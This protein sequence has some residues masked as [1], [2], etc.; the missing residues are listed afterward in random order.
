VADRLQRLSDATHAGLLASGS[1]VLRGDSLVFQTQVS[2]VQTG[3][4][5]LTLDAMAGS[6]T[7]PI[8]AVDALGDRLL[9][10][11]NLRR[12]IRIL[13]QGFRA[14][15]YAAYREFA[16][17]YER[18]AE[19]GDNIGSRPFFERAI[20]LDSTYTQ[21][22]QLLVRQY[23]NAD[24][25][26]RAD[27]LMRRIDRLPGGLTATER[28]QRDYAQAE[29]DGNVPGLLRAAEQLV[30]RDSS[31]LALFLTGEAATFLLKP[32]LAVPALESAGATYGLIGGQAAI[33]LKNTLAEA[34][35]Q[36]GMHDRELKTLV[37]TQR[38]FAATVPQ[39]RG[40]RLRAYAGLRDGTTA[41]AVADS[42]L[43]DASDSTGDAATRVLRGAEEFRA[44]GDQA[45]AA[46][47]LAMAR[48]WYARIPARTPTPARRVSEG[49]A[50]L[51]SGIGDSAAVRFAAVARD[52]SRID[53]AGYL[54]LANVVRGDRAQARAIADSLGAMR[55]P[56][57][58]GVHTFWRGAIMG[59]LGD[60]PLAVQLL[61]QASA[62]GQWMD[63]WHY[64]SA[65]DSLHGY[66]PFEALIRPER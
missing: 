18:F 63:S 32:A 1:V 22:Y 5:V 42:M 55:R 48:A 56:W 62:E 26:G 31:A 65:L 20:A 24:E 25:Y 60:R 40:R 10:G 4:A 30:A 9:G 51:M 33:V 3:K 47:L 46:R 54:A 59:A 19:R 7:D 41:V 58:H 37:A 29:L 52:T 36:A 53:A 16:A 12:E 14:P 2:D 45:T 13:P 38:T 39:L 27:S 49:I 64:T 43:R 6:A 23:L 15:K 8:A 66:G 11:L 44:H 17:G 57:L 21:A 50:M 61:R 34:Y 35:H 28:L